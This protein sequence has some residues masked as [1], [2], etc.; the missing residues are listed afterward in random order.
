V[1]LALQQRNAA[2]GLCVALLLQAL[3]VAPVLGQDLLLLDLLR[4]IDRF[5]QRPKRRRGR[6]RA[7]RGGMI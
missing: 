4:R 5:S 2:L 1:D 6:G 3:G 7:G